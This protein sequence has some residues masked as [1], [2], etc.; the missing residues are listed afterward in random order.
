MAKGIILDKC[1]F[2]GESITDFDAEVREGVVYHLRVLC[3][4]DF[5]L[6]GTAKFGAD[7]MWNRRAFQVKGCV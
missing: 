7:E 6:R 5:D 1:P 2:C 3:C 4:G